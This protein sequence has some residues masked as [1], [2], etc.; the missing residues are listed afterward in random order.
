MWNT[1]II[2]ERT[3][4]P[5]EA[6]RLLEMDGAAILTWGRTDGE[7]ATAAAKAVLGNRLRA[8]REPIG[9][10]PNP[11]SGQGTR[12]DWKTRTVNA[13]STVEQAIHIDGYMMY[14]SAYPDFIFLLCAEQAPSGGDSF[15]ADGQR[16]I[17]A[18]AS[19]PTLR[20]LSRFLWQVPIEQSTPEGIP[21]RNPIV[22]R[23]SAGR[24]TVR[25]HDHQRLPDDAPANSEMQRLLDRWFAIT[26]EAAAA[27]RFRLQAGD[28]LCL[29]N[30]RVFHGREPYSGGHRLLH[31]IWSWSDLAF[32]VPDVNAADNRRAAAQTHRMA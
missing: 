21:S 20:E 10:Q 16:L 3:D 28:F 32:A 14:G 17:N 30:Y 5:T 25:Y 8:Q 7:A 12:F 22:S 24:I 26:N 15:I 27:P 2:P 31:R 23:T 11:T 6:Y 18:I 1:G 29:D 19:D 9:I 13:D 4:D